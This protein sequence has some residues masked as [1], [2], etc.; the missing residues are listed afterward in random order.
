MSLYRKLQSE[1]TRLEELVN[2]GDFIRLVANDANLEDKR[3]VEDMVDKYRLLLVNLKAASENLKS[4]VDKI[5]SET[6]HRIQAGLTQGLD[7]KSIAAE[8]GEE[9]E[10]GVYPSIK[11][12][13]NNK[14][15]I[16]AL[17]NSDLYREALGC[18]ALKTEESIVSSKLTEEM[19]EELKSFERKKIYR[20]SI[21]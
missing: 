5:K 18:G 19:K 16:M 7:A 2:S 12:D 9:Y 10:C 17:K 11:V 13:Y 21:R 6:R 1:I 3:L 15:A 4:E 8:I 20:L 14:D